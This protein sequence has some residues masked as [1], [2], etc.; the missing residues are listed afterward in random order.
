MKMSSLTFVE[1]TKPGSAVPCRGDLYALM[2]TEH[3]ELDELLAKAAGKGGA[4]DPEAYQHFRE[5][6]LKHIRI[7]ERILI[8]MAERKRGEAI[9][10]AG[11]LRLDH[12]ALAALLML[13]PADR[14]FRA[15]R[16]VL[17]AHNPLEEREGGVYEHC[18]NLAGSEI[19]ELLTQIA[20]TPRVPVSPW[21]DSPS[22]L[23]AAQRVMARAGHDP[24]LLGPFDGTLQ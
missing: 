14:A 3:A 12:G 10:I 1:E 16:A 2:A 15:I 17:A 6:L 19:N 13:P 4:V 5:R 24:S 22:V 9:S 11:R 23:A 8:P 21:A 20:A 7:E 18:E